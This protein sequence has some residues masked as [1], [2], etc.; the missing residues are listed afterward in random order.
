MLFNDV[1]DSAISI[2]LSV[3]SDNMKLDPIKILTLLVRCP[4]TSKAEILKQNLTHA[5]LLEIQIIFHVSIIC[6]VIWGK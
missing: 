5:V 6:L 4:V 3:K 2:G 1:T